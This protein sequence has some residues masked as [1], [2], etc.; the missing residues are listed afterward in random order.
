M[1]SFDQP[2]QGLQRAE[3]RL[4]TAAGRIANVSDPQDSVDL[5]AE[6]VEL[7]ASKIDFGASVKAIQTQDEISKSLLDVLA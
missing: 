1:L 6:M 7:L 5:S 2:L 4:E 3:S